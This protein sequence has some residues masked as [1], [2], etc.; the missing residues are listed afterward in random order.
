M[1]TQQ[2]PPEDVD[3]DI[4]GLLHEVWQ[5]KIGI[6]II[7]AITG[8]ALF[9][10]FTSVSPKYL[11]D[12][13]IL[14]EN[15]ESVFTRTTE[16]AGRANIIDK[17]SIGSQVEVIYSDSVTLAVIKKLGL[18]KLG[19]FGAE[20]KGSV[21]SD[22]LVLFGIIERKEMTSPEAKILEKFK[23]QLKVYSIDNSR[24]IVVE[25]SSKNPKVA[26]SVANEMT[27]EYLKLQKEASLSATLDA[28]QWLGPEIEKLRDKVRA[29]EAAVVSY[30][31]N[32]DILV[33][34]NNA[35]LATQQLSEISSE[36]TRLRAERSNAQA[37]VASMR[38]SLKK[39]SSLESV[40]EVANSVIVQR[41]RENQLAVSAQ[42]AD[43]STSLLPNHPRLKA[44]QSQS[45][46]FDRQIKAAAKT[47][48]TGMQD[49]VGF[50]REKEDQLRVEMNRL[51]AESS[52]VGEAEVELR[53]LER[54]ATAERELLKSYLARYREADSRQNS[55]Y[56][57]V[58][59]RI[60]SKA[61]LPLKPYFPKIVPYSVAGS[62]AALIL[63][64][65]GV[66]AGALINGRAFK[67]VGQ[68]SAQNETASD[69]RNDGSPESIKIYTEMNVVEVLA[70]LEKARVVIMSEGQDQLPSVSWK[71]A[72]NLALMG[73]N[74]VLIDL[75]AEQ[76]ASTAMLG[77]NNLM[78]IGDVMHGSIGLAQAVY[79]DRN[80][81]AQIIPVG[82]GLVHNGQAGTDQ[83]SQLVDG[84][85]QNFDFLILD[86]SG[87][88]ADGIYPVAREDTIIVV[89]TGG[90]DIENCQILDES[91]SQ[92]GYLDVVM[93]KADAQ[94]PTP[95]NQAPIP[96][97]A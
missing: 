96:Q 36:L 79:R 60:I 38:K 86:C 32:S 12:S 14:I 80:S 66:L 21:I 43:L 29:A 89:N 67:P 87:S 16:R 53:A 82:S 30:R 19:E 88:S 78:G 11:S 3:I 56:V 59:A 35:S 39:G 41:L 97:A 92:R 25:F 90:D 13:R 54:E 31:A 4:K 7:S 61:N 58:N 76:E 1:S 81:S 5:R 18:S 9:A 27:V 37:R 48:L 63:S 72:R 20:N 77:G 28:T 94:T 24:V 74:V 62:V 17:E 70:G 69:V 40:P 15:R 50:T 49:N 91:L 46:G 23:D 51:K 65:I 42:I 22:V 83:L 57:P 8:M 75:S 2:L 10:I 93:M 47:I 44:L 33:G 85:S 45:K 84:L 73:R 64:V 6:A 26:Q 71:I 34:N 52:R 95:V 68:Q 55:R